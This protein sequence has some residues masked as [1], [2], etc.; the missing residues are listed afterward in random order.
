MRDKDFN[1]FGTAREWDLSMSMCGF[2]TYTEYG[3]LNIHTQKSSKFTLK[4][5]QTKPS[6]ADAQ[7]LGTIGTSD[8]LKIIF[9]D[10]SK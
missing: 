2:Y 7:G 6:Q 5:A 1:S 3:T 10:Y 8:F 4:V 9:I